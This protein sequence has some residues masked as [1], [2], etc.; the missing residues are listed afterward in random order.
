MKAVVMAGG[1]GARL[2]PLT[3]GRPKPMVP[4]VNKPVLA[5]ILDLLKS[6]G[7]TEVVITL[8]YLASY[9]QD[10][11]EDGSN[12]GMKLSYTVEEGPLGTAGSVK[13]AAALLDETFLVISGDALTDFDLTAIIR[14]H[15]AQ[16]A[17]ATLTLAHVP[18]PLEYGLVVTN[19]GG[20]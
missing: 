20:Y 1:E 14:A 8:R 19:E 10:F 7:I 11:F 3:V 2:R 4:I 15:Q 9:I 5:H 12:L 13:N 18:N 6:H 17:L 16:G